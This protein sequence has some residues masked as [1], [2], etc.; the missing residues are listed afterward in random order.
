MITFNKNIYCLW[1]RDWT[2]HALLECNRVGA[3]CTRSFHKCVRACVFLTFRCILRNGP[4]AE[5]HLSVRLSHSATARA[6]AVL[7]ARQR[8]ERAQ[9]ESSGGGARE[10][11]RTFVLLIKATKMLK[12][13]EKIYYYY[14]KKKKKKYHPA[15]LPGWTITI[16]IIIILKDSSRA[17]CVWGGTRAFSRAQVWGK[18]GAGTAPCEGVD[19]SVRQGGRETGSM[20]RCSHD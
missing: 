20:S 15:P 18:E 8:T 19:T 12:K 2:H 10:H 13:W 14:L 3:T 6:C 5:A 9:K 4:G 11:H 16:I 7:G 1:N 17:L